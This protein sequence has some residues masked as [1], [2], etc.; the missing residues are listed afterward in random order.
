M[1]KIFTI[2]FFLGVILYSNGQTKTYF[3]S[4]DGDDSNSG[5]SVKE[6]WKTIEKVNQVTFKPG[7]MLLLKSGG[8]WYGQMHPLGSGEENKPIIISKYGDGATPVINIGDAEGAAIR[9]VNQSWWEIRNIEITSGARPELGIGR[10]GIAALYEGTGATVKHIIIEDCFI[11]DVWGQMG[12]DSEYCGYNSAAIYVGRVLG[13]RQTRDGYYDYI[14]IQNNRIERVD[15]CGIVVFGGRKN[16]LVRKNYLEN[17]GGDAIFVNGPDKGLI[18]YNIAKRSCMRSGDLDLEGGENFWPHT[19]TIWIQNTEGTIMQYNEVYDTG[20]QPKNGDGFA[21]DFDFDANNC[22]LQYNYSRNN[23]GFLLIMNNTF[24]NITRYNISENDQT[25]LIQMQGSIEDQNL[26]HN[27]VFY[28]DYSTIDLDFYIRQP[29]KNKIGAYFRNN[30]FYAHGQGRFRTVYTSGDVIGRE[31]D[32]TYKVPPS[33]ATQLYRSNC[34]FGT[35][36]N[37]IP[38][39][40]ER[41]LEDPMLVAPGT[42]GVGLSTLGGYKLKPGSPCI[43]RGMLIA[44]NADRDFFGN[45]IE[46]GSPDLG[47]YEQIGSGVFGDPSQQTELDRAEKAKQDLV[48][49]KMSFPQKLT[50]PE[51]GGDVTVTLSEALQNNISGTMTLTGRNVGV[52]PQTIAFGDKSRNNFVYKLQAVKTLY[53]LPEL[54]VQLENNGL[55]EEWKIPVYFSKKIE[56]KKLN[57]VTVDGNLNE[58]ESI[59]SIDINDKEQVYHMADKWNTIDDGACSFKAAISG[60]NLSIAINVVDNQLVTNEKLGDNVQ[61]IFRNLDVEDFRKFRAGHILLP[62]QEQNGVIKDAVITV[63]RNS[64]SPG[65]EVKTFY[66]KTEKGYTMELSI[67]FGSLGFDSVPGKETKLGFEIFLNNTQEQNGTVYQ[68]N[69]SGSGSPDN[70]IFNSIYSRFYVNN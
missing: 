45:P 18:E 11:H 10:Q 35:W 7:D 41:L 26:I 29:D 19:A 5:L 61:V 62:A 8:V 27:N 23:H 63:G 21:Y 47:A 33:V 43:N 31:F 9:L 67:P 2:I 38:E 44:F 25:H 58:W 48:W 15:K 70:S 50:L 12:G 42:G 46:D 54:S 32:D 66:N 24:G 6:P 17:L 53:P 28:V 68:I 3:L 49:A 56:L 57:N 30:I 60:E 22:V 40:P 14:L 52:R 4:P 34:F 16:V 36:I 20:R 37:G 13:G 39:D 1:K 69:M 59:S 51:E 55:T 65:T 64:V